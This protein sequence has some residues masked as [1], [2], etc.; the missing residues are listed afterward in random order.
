[1]KNK[2]PKPFSRE[3]V[4][5]ESILFLS[6]DTETEG[7]GGKLLMITACDMAKTH[8]F[9]GDSMLTDFFELLATMPYPA[10][11]YAHN[12]QY[13]W[14][15]ILPWI[16]EQDYHCQISM[17]TETDI[18]Q[19]VV[20][21][22]GNKIV[23]RDS[24]ALFPAKLADMAET[25]CPELPKGEIDI[26]HFD[27][28]NP[29]H[30]NYAKRDAE[31]LRRAMPRVDMLLRHHFGIGA[32]HTSAGTALKAWQATLPDGVF[33]NPSEWNEREQFIR[34]AYYGGLVFITRNDLIGSGKDIAA[35]TYDV[36]SCYP[37]VME[38]FGVPYG[39]VI[40]TDDYQSGIMGI[41][42]VKVTAPFDLVVPILPHRN[43]KGHM[44]WNGGTFE[45]IVTNAELIFAVNQGYVI[46]DI[47]EGL[48]FEETVFPFNSFIQRCKE[49]RKKYKG[50]P[51]EALAKLM[52]NSLFGKF[53][54]RRE[55]M[56][57]FH[58]QNNDDMTD[59]SPVDP[60]GYFWCRKEFEDNLR[61]LP[62]WAVF[63]TAHA[64]LKLLQQ[65]YA[66]GV[67]N[68]IYGDTDSITCLAGHAKKFDVGLEYGQFKLEKQWTSFRAIAPKVYVGTLPD[69]TYKGAA[70]GMRRASMERE[71][72]RALHE[73]R[74]IRLA[75]PS[76]PSLRVAMKEGMK[77][78]RIVERSSTSLDNSANWQLTIDGVRPKLAACERT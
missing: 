24:L 9:T 4:K 42:R 44:Q 18:Y 50:Q 78:A 74:R 43:N 67:E 10:I 28:K 32:G 60:D 64:R 8:V 6:F 62:Q 23:M 20:F 72:W 21:I 35:E 73:G 41:Y 58:P 66:V 39:R 15:Y 49:I 68:V 7:L 59:A 27:V 77:P 65:V 63:I 69:G 33:Y 5:D 25:F 56:S 12:A 16:I 3:A 71:H 34:A 54:S 51:Q 48:A 61:A 52:Q 45:T 47:Y 57:I 14:R 46:E 19:V 31:I 36:N 22:D 2:K 55:R 17:R 37:H 76:L 26:A 30:V 40:E 11:W 70:K 38:T 13:D 1:M 75:Y 29:E 53:G